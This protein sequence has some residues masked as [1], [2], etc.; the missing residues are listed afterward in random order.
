MTRKPVVCY[1]VERLH[2][3]ISAYHGVHPRVQSTQTPLSLS[4]VSE[5]VLYFI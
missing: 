5:D 1:C 2:I 3:M 4:Q